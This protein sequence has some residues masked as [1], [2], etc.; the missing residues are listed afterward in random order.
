MPRSKSYKVKIKNR[1]RFIEGSNNIFLDLG[2]PKH[3][4]INLS[5][6][7]SLMMIVEKT[8]RNHGWTQTQAAK[9]LGVGQPRVSD[10]Y[11]G[12]IDRFTV[13]MLMIWLHKLGKEIVVSVKG[14][15]A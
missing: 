1:V 11:Q 12:K 5:V 15:V 10:L 9:K 7:S 8:I 4:A 13:D 3:D 6:R 2:F 14:E